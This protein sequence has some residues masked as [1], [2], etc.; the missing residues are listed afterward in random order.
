MKKSSD[1]SGSFLNQPRLT[2][3]DVQAQDI[4]I[5]GAPHGTPYNERN[6]VGY[7]VETRSA[8]APGAIRVAA[9]ES[10]TNIDHFDFDLGG[11]LMGDGRRRLVD[12]G[13][14]DLQAQDG[15]TNRAAITNA[16]AAILARQA[17]P[18]LLGGDDS[19]PIPFL[20]AFADR[21]PV[22]ILQIDAHIDW[23]DSIGG[24]PLGYSSTMRRASEQPFVRSITQVGM[25]GVGSARAGE[26]DAALEWGARLITV[27]E[28]R[29]LGAQGIAD[30][31]PIGG[32][33]LIH[34]D[35]DAFDTSVCPAVNAPTP[36][37]FM[38]NEVA[39]IVRSAI[40][41]HGLGGFSIVE[42]VPDEDRN[43]ISAIVAARI[44]CNAIGALARYNQ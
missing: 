9:N 32:T 23:R 35:C 30:L 43:M 27:T 36:G 19:V 26:V 11:P 8:S 42:L 3:A 38:F 14:L 24:E 37:G 2:P 40:A 4:A 20:A 28:S 33:L 7:V 16:T 39:D 6:E 1:L 10:S 13:D 31:I 22:D 15:Q 21:G 41:A 25:R 18:L 29:R 44:T 17:T 12:C 5:L 34:I